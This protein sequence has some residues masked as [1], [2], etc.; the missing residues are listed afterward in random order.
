MNAPGAYIMHCCI[1]YL[2]CQTIM[3]ITTT[4]CLIPAIKT[5]EFSWT[6]NSYRPGKLLILFVH[7]VYIGTI[8]LPLVSTEP[9]LQYI[10]KWQSSG[11]VAFTAICMLSTEIGRQP[12][13][14]VP[15]WS[16]AQVK[17]WCLYRCI[18]R[19]AQNGDMTMTNQY[20]ARFSSRRSRVH[21]RCAV[22]I[23]SAS[24]YNY[25][26][27]RLSTCF[28]VLLPNFPKLCNYITKSKHTHIILLP[29]INL[30]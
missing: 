24:V 1:F 4:R 8:S 23:N 20:T 28:F 17:S 2:S 22:S 13:C 15:D 7:W 26:R 14:A 11:V 18:V 30:S 27:F 6:G 16:T 21:S 5:P 29:Y 12:L 19:E 9:M 10:Q 25:V 3:D